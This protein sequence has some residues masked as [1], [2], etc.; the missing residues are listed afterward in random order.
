[1]KTTFLLSI[2]TLALLLNSCS[3]DDDSPS[4]ADSQQ[5]LTLHFN[6]DNKLGEGA[7]LAILKVKD[8]EASYE[9]LNETYPYNSLSQN[10]EVKNNRVGIGLHTDFN[11]PNTNRQHNGAWFD[12]SDGNYEILPLLPPG[13]GRYSFFSVYTA[14]VSNSGHVFYINGSQDIGWL[15]NYRG[16][17]VRYN[18]T[19]DVL[20]AAT[21]PGSFAVNQPE[22]GWDTETGQFKGGFYPSSDGRFVYGVIETFGVDGG[23]IHWDYKILFKYDFETEEYTRLGDAEDS[24]VSLYGMTSD[25]RELL[26][27]NSTER[28]TVNVNTNTTTK[29]TI[30]GGQGYTNTSRWNN[31]GYCSG[32]TNNTIGIYNL[33]SDESYS[34]KTPGR[35]YYAQFSADGKRIYFMLESPIARYLCKT[36]N[37]S[38][39]AVI[40]TLCTLSSEVK[41]FMVIK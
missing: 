8:G 25:G 35:P 23:A 41:E 27:Y 13:N 6:Q 36:N 34:I 16:A 21:D 38:E 33:L 30:S 40:D 2:L 28:K 19:T 31:S 14:K 7:Y 26:Y 10:L 20:D 24:Q 15:D 17:L 11:V 5:F 1:M 12:L 3:S 32:E 4:G 37:L 9:K 39:E 22:K 18:P 29:I